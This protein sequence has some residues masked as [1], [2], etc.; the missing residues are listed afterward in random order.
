[1]NNLV[2]PEMFMAEGGL[3]DATHILRNYHKQALAETMKAREIENEVVA[4]LSGLRS[5]LG[6]KI[7]EIKSLSGD[8]KNSVD[9]EKE[10]TRK[11]VGALQEALAAVDANSHVAGK[12][13]PYI[14][15][16]AVERQA[17][18]QIDEE[19]YLHRVCIPISI[20][21]CE[22]IEILGIPQHGK[23]RPR[24]RVD[25]S[26]GNPKGLQCFCHYYQE[27]GRRSIRYSR[28]TSFWSYHRSKGL[29]V[30][31]ILGE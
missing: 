18:R 19:N 23:L 7:K 26:R 30:D 21:S 9:K 31:R 29:R 25:C 16:L 4:Q 15:R 22:L 14:V 11:A 2:P 13:D 17:E 3:N 12:D 1:M 20:Q 6:Q 8:F 5:D 24:A 28:E 27:G 10:G